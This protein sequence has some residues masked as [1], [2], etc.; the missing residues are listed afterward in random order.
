MS[1][2]NYEPSASR[3]WYETNIKGAKSGTLDISNQASPVVIFDTPRGPY[4]TPLNQLC[5]H[6]E[7]IRERF[8]REIWAKELCAAADRHKEV[9]NAI[10]M[11]AQE[12]EGVTY[13]KEFRFNIN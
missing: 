13:A 1:T 3:I 9:A 6:R 10:V 11:G 8:G 2:S 12:S 4:S 5:G 7:A